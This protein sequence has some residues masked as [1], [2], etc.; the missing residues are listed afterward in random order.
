MNPGVMIQVIA[1]RFTYAAARRLA[2]EPTRTDSCTS[3]SWRRRIR[4]VFGAAENGRDLES[5]IARPAQ[6]PH[7]WSRLPGSPTGRCS[8]GCPDRTCL[9]G[10]LGTGRQRAD[11]TLSGDGRPPTRTLSSRS[12]GQEFRPLWTGAG[13]SG[14]SAQS[15]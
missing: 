12:L 11:F 3:C 2:V 1:P 13:D 10:T 4:A 14:N 9:P 8:D 7:S 6:A 5:F 15:G